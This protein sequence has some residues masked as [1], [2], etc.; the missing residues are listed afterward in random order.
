MSDQDRP[1]HADQL[2]EGFRKVAGGVRCV[3]CGRG[4]R[5]PADSRVNHDNFIFLVDHVNEHTMEV[6]EVNGHA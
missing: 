5:L 6:S 2:G 4:W 3:H 1:F